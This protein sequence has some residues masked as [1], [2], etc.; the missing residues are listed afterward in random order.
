MV[1]DLTAAHGERF[2]WDGLTG[3]EIERNTAGDPP[4]DVDQAAHL[5]V[6]EL[7]LSNGPTTVLD[8][9]CGVGRLTREV[10]RRKPWANVIGVDVS[11]SMIMHAKET[12]RGE[13]GGP[14]PV[15]LVN[16]GRWLPEAV[17]RLNGAYSVTVFQHI[18]PEAQRSYIEQVA[19]KL[20]G[21]AMFVFTVSEGSES[22]FLSHQVKIDDVL[23]WC[24][25]AGFYLE[26]YLRNAVVHGWTWVLAR[27]VAKP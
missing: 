13:P 10:A 14:D 21:G 15:Y 5:I 18:P 25:K 11:P 1:T 17:G 23:D 12:S 26:G 4:Y 6:R 27:K 20:H 19:A 8:L 2:W 22:A 24:R 7:G 3:D 9:G 16:D